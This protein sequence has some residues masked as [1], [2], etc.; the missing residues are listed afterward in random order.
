MSLVTK[1]TQ[2]AP[3]L[4]CGHLLQKRK[5]TTQLLGIITRT[6]PH[7]PQSDGMVERFNRTLEAQ[8]A[9]FADINKYNISLYVS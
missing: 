8:P 5:M 4:S 6:T 7:H 2:R 1:H 3:L 9:K